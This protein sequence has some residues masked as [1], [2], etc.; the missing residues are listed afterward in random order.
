M[1]CEIND[2]LVVCTFQMNDNFFP[3]LVIFQFLKITIF[4]TEQEGAKI[5]LSWKKSQLSSFAEK[6]KKKHLTPFF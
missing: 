5:K 3:L 1:V 6:N 2:K 4:V